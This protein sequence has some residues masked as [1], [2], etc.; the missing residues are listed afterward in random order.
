[1]TPP[2]WIRSHL[3]AVGITGMALC[4]LQTA[5]AQDVYRL[6]SDDEWKL[7]SAPAPGTAA[8]QLA[9]ARTLL[10]EGRPDRAHNMVN[11]WMQ[12]HP[13]SSLAPEAYLIRGESL[14]GIGDEY[15]ALYDFE[16]LVRKYPGSEVF[17]LALEQE[18]GIAVRYA[19]GL[20]RKMFGLR[21]INASDEAEE[22]LIRIQERLPGSG[23]AEQAGL[24]LAALYF[25]DRRMGLAADAYSIF[26]KRYPRSTEIPFARRRLIYANIATFK[27]PQFDIIGL[28]EA[29]AELQQLAIRRPAE[30]ERIGAGALIQRI[31]E[32]QSTK[33]LTTALWY[34]NEGD[35]I[36]A[37]YTIRKLVQRFPRSAA[38]V[39]ALHAIG[40]IL[41][42]LPPI[43]RD[44][45]PDYAMLRTT[46][47]ASPPP[48]TE[49]D[50]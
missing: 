39:R 14:V 35:P 5:M 26:I 13:H 30:A 15:E 49:M 4:G 7:E 12:R 23:L 6:G 43:I 40:P 36:A 22:L 25:R 28:L 44:T 37:E 47:Q 21:I 48:T 33:M 46:L 50:E 18:Y 2:T 32:S 31:E 34:F 20:R 16:F 11:R 27:G 19:N 8:A 3:I 29:K 41:K 38:C 17:S 24:Q 42:E 45:T 1:M 10:A 9:R